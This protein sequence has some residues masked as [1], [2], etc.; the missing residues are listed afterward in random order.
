MDQGD[1]N[2]KADIDNAAADGNNLSDIFLLG[3]CVTA[4][5]IHWYP[6]DEV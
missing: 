5:P 4:L 6:P 3:I 1:S 2:G